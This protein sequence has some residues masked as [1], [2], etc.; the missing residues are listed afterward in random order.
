MHKFIDR[1]KWQPVFLE[2]SHGS[3]LPFILWAECK[4]AGFA[5]RIKT[6]TQIIK[7]MINIVLPIYT[8]LHV[9]FI[10]AKSLR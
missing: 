5:R 8:C 7:F 10:P 2:Q 1:K 3:A 6:K 4:T 9:D